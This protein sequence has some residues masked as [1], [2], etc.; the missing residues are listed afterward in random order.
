MIFFP[1]GQINSYL[2]LFTKFFLVLNQ[3]LNRYILYIVLNKATLS[4]QTINT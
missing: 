2:L 4:N 3:I 1:S